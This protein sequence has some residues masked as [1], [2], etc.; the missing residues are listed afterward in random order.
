MFRDADLIQEY[1]L[2]SPCC[3]IRACRLTLFARLILKA[4]IH[5]LELIRNMYQYDIGW[6]RALKEDLLWLSLSGELSCSCEDLNAVEALKTIR[7]SLY[8]DGAPIRCHQVC[9]FRCAK[10]FTQICRELLCTS[11]LPRLL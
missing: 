5:I 7:A 6:I 2:V 8:Q 4:P 1:S 9:Q 11:S 3:M 10:S